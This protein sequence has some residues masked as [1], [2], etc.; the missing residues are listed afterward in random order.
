MLRRILSALGLRKKPQVSRPTKKISTLNR[1]QKQS[2]LSAVEIETLR[3]QRR[4]QPP[5]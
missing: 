4:K 2:A 3:A 5:R 1:L